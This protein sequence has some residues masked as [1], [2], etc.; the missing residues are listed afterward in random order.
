M[1]LKKSTTEEGAIRIG[2]RAQT[3]MSNLVSVIG[4]M[5]VITI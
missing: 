2:G 5:A 3:T 1:Y 4:Q